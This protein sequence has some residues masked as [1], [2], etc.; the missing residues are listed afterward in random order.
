[1]DVWT[2]CARLFLATGLLL[3]KSGHRP[4]VGSLPALSWLDQGEI[5]SRASRFGLH[6]TE[7]PREIFLLVFNA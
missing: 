3:Q 1:M 4:A 5:L 2:S 6:P 7:G